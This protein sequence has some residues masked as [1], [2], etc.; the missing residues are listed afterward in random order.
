M[1]LLCRW[2]AFRD[3]IYREK[4]VYFRVLFPWASPYRDR[5]HPASAHQELASIIGI[6]LFGAVLFGSILIVKRNVKQK[7]GDEAGSWRLA[8]SLFFVF[9]AMWALQAHH[10]ASLHEFGTIVPARAWAVPRPHLRVD[11][12]FRTGAVC[13]QARGALAGQPLFSAKVLDD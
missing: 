6:V 5:L 7:R 4:P 3:V 11:A 1:A 12:L 2:N 10:L 8:N 9:L 13:S